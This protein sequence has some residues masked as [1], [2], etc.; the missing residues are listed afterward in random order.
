[1][2]KTYASIF[3]LGSRS[4]TDDADG[5]VTPVDNAPVPDESAVRT[6]LASFVGRIDQVPPAYS[7]AKIEGKRAHSL[8][9]QGQ[10]VKLSARPVDIDEINVLGYSYPRLEVEVHCGKGTYIRSLARDLGQRLGC[11]GLVEVLR[12]TRVGPFK[13]DDAIDIDPPPSDLREFLLPAS[14][15]LYDLPEVSVSNQDATRF[16]QGQRIRAR[17][18]AEGPAQEVAVYDETYTLLGVAL[19]DPARNELRPAKVL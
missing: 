17:T 11:G 14:L 4:D 19:T 8:A 13:A 10:E 18:V 3:L 6:A 16:R 2:A 9:R 7:A 5:T 15:A 12:R 1:M